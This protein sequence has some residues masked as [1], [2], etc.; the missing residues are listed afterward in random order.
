[1]QCD[2][3]NRQCAIILPE[4]INIEYYEISFQIDNVT[5]VSCKIPCS[6]YVKQL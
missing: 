4:I 2:R 6:H 5:I 3:Q 1:M